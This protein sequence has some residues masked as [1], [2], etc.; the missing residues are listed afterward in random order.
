[1]FFIRKNKENSLKL[2]KAG[3]AGKVVPLYENVEENF[4]NSPVFANYNDYCHR[5]GNKDVFMVAGESMAQ[6]FVHTGDL[7]FCSLA[8][9]IDW[10]ATYKLIV[11]KVNRNRLKCKNEIDF[12]FKLRKYVMTI[13]MN[14]GLEA[15]LENL[16]Q[17]D[18][19]AKYSLENQGLFKTKYKKAN[20]EI[21]AKENVL[22]SVT[23]TNR[24]R[25]YSFH[26]QQDLHA[27][28]DCVFS[29]TDVGYV[30]ND[31]IN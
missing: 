15:N 23:Y 10:I 30:L 3:E 22:V 18:D 1:M 26:E 9:N 28:V 11:L 24:G 6:G 16:K 14:D 31:K 5:I 19:L 17:V 29:K 2:V 20:N 8:E 27:I 4:W 12:G 7:L 21:I 13:D 25:E